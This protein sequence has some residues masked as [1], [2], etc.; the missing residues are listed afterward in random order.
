MNDRAIDLNLFRVF[1]EVWRAESL[2]QAARKLHLTQPAVSNALARLRAHFDDPLFV[3]DGRRMLPTP[4][5][6]AVAPQVL[7]ALAVLED[8]AQA[9]PAAFDPGRSTRRFTLGMRE[10]VESAVVPELGQLCARS[11][12]GLAL[13]SVRFERKELARLLYS[14]ALDAAIDVQMPIRG[15]VHHRPLFQEELCL[16]LRR[17]HPLER[18]RLISQ[19]AFL[20]ARHVAVS[21]RARGTT[22]EDVLL[23][24]QGLSREVAVRCQ[25]YYAACALVSQ[26]D[27]LLIAP[28][29]YVERLHAHLD[30]AL[31]PLPVPLPKLELTLYWHESPVRDPGLHWLIEQ[32]CA[33]SA[34]YVGHE[35]GAWEIGSIG[36]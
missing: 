27:L 24:Q 33:A 14:G 31:L 17:G 28:R 29:R 21:A 34:G 8:A 11:A 1:V 18:S 22:L 19:S 5:A 7:S 26:T 36:E 20:S 2:T 10:V 4:R 6:R 13:H 3:R 30:L 9:Q 35:N 12:P 32:I 25:H 23:A 16:A 15:G